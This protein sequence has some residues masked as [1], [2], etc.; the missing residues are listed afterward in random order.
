MTID[1][2][3][4]VFLATILVPLAAGLLLLLGRWPAPLV[5]QLSVIAT[6]VTLILSLGLAIQFPSLHAPST[7]FKTPVAPRIALRYDWLTFQ[8]HGLDHIGQPDSHLEFYLG[9]DGI[10]LSLVV[11]TSLL[12]FSAVLISWQAIGERVR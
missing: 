12:T 4:A 11:L 5:R 8:P 2:I 9:L 3:H 10:G 1:P 7:G 6:V